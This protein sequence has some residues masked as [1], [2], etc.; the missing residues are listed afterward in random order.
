MDEPTA[1]VGRNPA[2]CFV[3]LWRR[4]N[5]PP[6]VFAFLSACPDAPLADKATICEIDQVHR[7]QAGVPLQA[8]IYF[9]RLPDL[10]SEIALKLRLIVS[11]FV[12][13][14]RWGL[15]ASVADCIA[16]FPDLGDQLR[17]QLSHR[18]DEAPG[19]NGRPPSTVTV[20]PTVAA[21]DPGAGSPDAADFSEIFAEAGDA[22]ATHPS[23]IGR[24]RVL[25]ILG[26]G[27]FGRV[28]LAYDDIL[29][30]QVAIKVPHPHRISGP[31]DVENYLNE[32]R[33][34]ARLDDREVSIVPVYDCGQTDDGLCYVV[35]KYI[36]GSDLATKTRRTPLTYS[37]SAELVS[38]VATALHAAH[39]Q[40]VVHR[41]VKPAN[42]LID[43]NDR[44]FLTDFG[45]ALKE[46]D[47]GRGDRILGTIPYM[48]PEQLRGE[49]H[50][51][52]GRSD[53]FS[54]GIVLYELICG[55]RP[56]ASNRLAEPAGVEPRPPRQINDAIPKELERICLK[57]V[58]YRVSERYNTALDLAT[59]L[60]DYLKVTSG[61]GAPK[62]VVA[63]L[64]NSGISPTSG[65]SAAREITIIPKGLRS[66]DRD[67]AGFFLELLPGPRD[68]EGLPES[69]H[70][71]RTRIRE[72][73]PEKTFRVGLLYGPSGC[74]K[75]SLAK[76]YLQPVPWSVRLFSA[77]TTDQVSCSHRR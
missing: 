55:R 33:I 66:F 75:S 25:R 35:S 58:S 52:D 70:F 56:F 16:R 32:A 29:L 2:A 69:I 36:E 6:D 68:K 12:C 18:A 22:S 21:N 14:R 39:L 20:G 60:G 31:A 42:I 15:D 28:Y 13:R 30:R 41:D 37:A 76:P 43:V 65:V 77:G 23:K 5:S 59:D 49:G 40:G 11:E 48:S 8:E 50:L 71:W 17:V 64:S 26:D 7:W 51:V 19:E 74:G 62:M 10:A 34:V 3:E 47:Y 9:E 53:I 27:G 24:Y 4:P 38:K 72:T 67:D 57:A 73:D 1:S 45:I 61:S 44:P 63:S 54:L 46:E